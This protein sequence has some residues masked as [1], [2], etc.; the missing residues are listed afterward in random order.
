MSVAA[1]DSRPAMARR[2]RDLARKVEGRPRTQYNFHKIMSRV[3]LICM[4]VTLPVVIFA[5]VFWA[6]IGILLVAEISYYAN[7]A[8][9]ASGMAAANAST[10][11]SITAYAIE[12]DATATTASASEVVIATAQAARPATAP[13]AGSGGSPGIGKQ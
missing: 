1:G 3:W 8:T 4:V 6:K 11:E 5:P 2:I 9:D 7:Y 12:A 13:P 10:D